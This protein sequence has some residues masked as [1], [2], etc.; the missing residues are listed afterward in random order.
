MTPRQ[1]EDIIIIAR[2]S[3]QRP[4]PVFLNWVRIK[5]AKGEITEADAGELYDLLRIEF[6]TYWRGESSEPNAN[7]R[8]V[9]IAKVKRAITHKE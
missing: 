3:A 1:R 2:H 6:N 9:A 5:A 7:S 4:W 8:L